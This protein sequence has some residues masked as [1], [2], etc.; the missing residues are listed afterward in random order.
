[1]T[2]LYYL[3]LLLAPFWNYP[4]LPQVGSLTVIKMVGISVLLASAV[5]LLIDARPPRLMSWGETRLFTVFFLLTCV[6]AATVSAPDA[7]LLAVQ[8]QLASAAFLFGGPIFLDRT[9]KLVRA[10][11]VVLGSMVLA[12]YSVFV[13]YFR[14]G[15]GRPGGIIGDPNYYA[16]I[17]VSILPLVLFLLPDASPLAKC[18][19]AG[20]G[21]LMLSTILL[22]QSRGG[23]VALSVCIVYALLK[24]RRRAAA[25][26]CG[27]PLL[28]IFLALTPGNPLG[29]FREESASSKIS[30]ELRR[31]LVRSAWNMARQKPLVGVGVGMMK[32]LSTAYNPELGIPGIALN[33][34][35]EVAAEMGFPACAVFVLT[36]GWSWAR[37][38]RQA[39]SFEERGDDL[40][41][42]LASALE[43]GIASFSVGAVFLSAEYTKQLWILMSFVLALDRLADGG[44]G[45]PGET[46][47]ED[48]EAERDEDLEARVA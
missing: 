45:E 26:A 40:G 18:F 12:A 25:A 37:A 15:V 16:L 10:V 7:G 38:R 2:L 41:R 46:P 4:K 13:Q 21:A 1:M 47:D 42:R 6:S 28:L 24:S 17:A 3:M 39:R 36:I 22:G 44:A 27:I 29:R 9:E 32:P 5:K 11:Y 19:L 34:Y 31:Q 23:F 48:C 33:S 20:V 14:Y 43:V 30:T 35:L 8:V